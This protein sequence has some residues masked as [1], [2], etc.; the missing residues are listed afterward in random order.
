MNNET[1]ICEY[2]GLPNVQ[3]YQTEICTI[4]GTKLNEDGMCNMCLEQSNKRS[5]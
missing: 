3:A 5:S 4:H 1:L 2:S